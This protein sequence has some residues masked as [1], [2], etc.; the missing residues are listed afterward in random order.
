MVEI[1]ITDGM[2]IQEYQ[3]RFKALKP[4]DYFTVRQGAQQTTFLLVAII[5]ETTL[6]VI[7]V[8]KMLKQLTN[9]ISQI[10]QT[11]PDQTVTLQIPEISTYEYNHW[12]EIS[13]EKYD[14]LDHQETLKKMTGNEERLKELDE[15]TKKDPKA[16]MSDEDSFLL[17][18]RYQGQKQRLNQ[19]YIDNLEGLTKDAKE[20]GYLEEDIHDRTKKYPLVFVYYDDLDEDKIKGLLLPNHCY[21]NKFDAL[22]AKL[23]KMGLIEHGNNYNEFYRKGKFMRSPHVEDDY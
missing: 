7:N 13:S 19:F 17:Q 1:I 18:T 5:N 8:G 20:L 21:Y 16:I 2:R 14:N 6:Q 10:T 22:D 23:E 12:H 11:T 15:L 4:G 9:S 3:R